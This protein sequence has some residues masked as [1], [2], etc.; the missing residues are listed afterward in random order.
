MLLQIYNKAHVIFVVKYRDFLILSFFWH[1]YTGLELLGSTL[2]RRHFPHKGNVN[3]HY[4]AARTNKT[5]QKET[6]P[7]TLALRHRGPEEL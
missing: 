2:N 6:P 1:A 3:N 7:R 4:M 5:S